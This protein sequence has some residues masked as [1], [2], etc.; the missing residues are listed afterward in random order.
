MCSSRSELRPPDI[1]PRKVLV[2][3]VASAIVD[4]LTA[5]G[6]GARL[7]HSI[8]RLEEIV[9]LGRSRG[10][11]PVVRF[12]APEM[13]A[14]HFMRHA[15]RRISVRLVIPDLHDQALMIGAASS[16]EPR[17][18]MAEDRWSAAPHN[19][20]LA[21]K[22]DRGRACLKAPALSSSLQATTGLEQT[23]K[24]VVQLYNLAHPRWNRLR[25]CGR[26]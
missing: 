13:V 16:A 3:S 26:R 6:S 9:E 11:T 18:Q 2:R 20:T 22:T 24:L 19:R 4:E 10:E 23:E 8:A 7:E 15:F 12:D 25:R 14:E 17:R 21:T 5:A 1:A